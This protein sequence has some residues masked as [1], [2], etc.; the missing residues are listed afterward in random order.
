MNY[1]SIQLF[2]T[3]GILIGVWSNL[4]YQMNE[5]KFNKLNNLDREDIVQNLK[6]NDIIL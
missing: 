4:V 6:N 1:Y 3:S 2:L 5:I